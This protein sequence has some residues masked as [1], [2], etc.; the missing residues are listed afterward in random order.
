MGAFISKK[1]KHSLYSQ[2]WKTGLQLDKVKKNKESNPARGSCSSCLSR[3]TSSSTFSFSAAMIVF[4][5]T[6]WQ[7][8]TWDTFFSFS[9]FLSRPTPSLANSWAATVSLFTISK[10]A[11]RSSF[12]STLWATYALMVS[13]ASSRWK[14]WV[15]CR[16]RFQT[17]TTT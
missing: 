14:R 15:R 9:A 2:V 12:S 13:I 17:P 11:R 3:T 16:I 6:N 5:S 10:L 4:S 7:A 8:L 1:K